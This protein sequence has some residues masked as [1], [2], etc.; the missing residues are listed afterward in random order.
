MGVYSVVSG[1]CLLVMCMLYLQTVKKVNQNEKRDM[2]V[3]IMLTGILYNVAD[4]LWGI[5]YEEVIPIPVPIQKVIYAVFYATSAVLSYQWFVFVEYMQESV[6]Y[7]NK[8]IKQLVKIPVLFVVVLSFLSIWTGSLFYIGANGEYVRGDWYVLQLFMTYGYILFAVFKVVFFMFVTTEFEKQNTYIVIL[9]YFTFPIIFGVLQVF[10]QNVPYLCIGILLASIQHYLFSVKFEQEREI[11]VIKIHGLT[12][13]FINSYY[14]DLKTG[15]WQ[16][17][18]IPEEKNNFALKQEYYGKASKS[19]DEAI[20]FYAKNYIHADDRE[21]FLIMCSQ[22]YVREHLSREN[23]AYSFTYRQVAGEKEKWYRMHV[24]AASFEPDGKVMHAVMAIMDIDAQVTADFRHQQVLEQALM[25]AENA[26][27]AK[28]TFLSNMSHD[29][30]TPMNAII[31]FTNLA[32]ARSKNKESVDEYLEKIMSASKHLLSLINDILDMSRIESGKIQLEEDE[33]SLVDIVKE[34]NTLIQP[35]AAEK[36]IQLVIKTNITD[37]YVYCDKLRLNQVLINLLGNSVKF[38]PKGGRIYLHIKQERSPATKKYGKYVFKIKDNGIGMSEEFLSKIFQPFEREKAMDISGIQG[39]GLGLSIVKSIV[40]MMDGE[41][42]VNSELGKGSEFIIKVV[43]RIHE[44]ETHFISREDFE[45]Q[46]Q[47][48]EERTEE[49]SKDVFVGKKLLLV[50]DNDINREIAIEILTSEGFVVV[51]A[52]D[53]KEAVEIM[54]NATADEFAAVLMDVQMPVMDGYQAT[55]AI[56]NFQDAALA[57]IPIIAMTANAFDEDKKRAFE[58]GMNAHVAKPI[59]V[60][61]LFET[62]QQILK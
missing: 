40:E 57:N 37:N 24:V 23:R 49:K 31:G 5:I 48:E 8:L 45:K 11:G 14:L 42:S 52:A 59:E 51:E 10:N 13:L 6:F 35:M 30:R 62:L 53:G 18:S 27:K 19:Y 39:T 44:K 16:Y 9:S 43:F 7:R 41:I 33:I 20:D 32:Q 17:L 36:N 3:A 28:S 47:L 50:D 29:I 58:S 4:L 54:Q 25:Q 2:Y 60:D 56:R 46:N 38:T 15:A 55:K 26:N 61:V 12:Q 1:I 22:E 34:M 21:E